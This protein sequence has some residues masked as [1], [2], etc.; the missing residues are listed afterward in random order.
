MIN[1]HF[2]PTF[3][4][5]INFPNI[6]TNISSNQINTSDTCDSLTKKN[7]E[8]YIKNLYKKYKNLN[9]NSDVHQKL[10]KIKVYFI[11]KSID[12][13][14]KKTT[15]A[16]PI[17][18]LDDLS[19]SGYIKALTSRVGIF[20]M[21]TKTS[22]ENGVVNEGTPG[23]QPFLLQ[24]TLEC[25]GNFN[26][27]S[28]ISLEDL[29]IPYGFKEN[30]L[31]EEKTQLLQESKL[32][33][34]TQFIVDQ[35]G[36]GKTINYY[37]YQDQYEYDYVFL[38]NTI[39]TNVEQ[40]CTNP[41]DRDNLKTT[42]IDKLKNLKD[43]NLRDFWNEER[44]TLPILETVDIFYKNTDELMNKNII[45]IFSDFED[46]KNL[47]IT[48]IEEILE[49]Y[50]EYN[51]DKKNKLTS[52]INIDYSFN[53]KNGEIFDHTIMAK[54]KSYLLKYR[55]IKSNIE[56]EQHYQKNFNKSNMAKFSSE[57]LDLYNGSYINDFDEVLFNMMD[58]TKIVSMGLGDFLYFLN[59]KSIKNGEILFIPSSKELQKTQFSLL[60]LIK[61]KSKDRFFEYQ[62]EFHNKTKNYMSYYLY[63]LENS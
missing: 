53:F 63:E 47:L 7:N 46:A 32:K 18:T 28:D 43:L 25:D 45:P 15:V 2:I 62:K 39:F 5:N 21:K 20:Q 24:Y 48:T 35:N 31:S 3:S 13:D 22:F 57:N 16:I 1:R 51:F 10:N 37:V 41:R 29:E 11:A 33:L 38:D 9:N 17:N 59:N 6:L 60:P 19:N 12:I 14:S 34:Q 42:F 54:L 58:K 8:E 26:G 52:N 55:I 49:P 61:T 27:I 4:N 23:N 56:S 36:I 44:K 40:Y 50:K 30:N